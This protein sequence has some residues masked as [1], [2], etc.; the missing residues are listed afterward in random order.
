MAVW[1]GSARGIVKDA[2]VAGVAGVVAAVAVA[3][4]AAAAIEE[5]HRRSLAS[6]K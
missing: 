5:S 1:V 2:D 6:S 4:A 3:V